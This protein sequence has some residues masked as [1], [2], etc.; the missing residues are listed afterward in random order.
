[1][2]P[3]ERFERWRTIRRTRRIASEYDDA[4]SEGHQEAL[5]ASEPYRRQRQRFADEHREWQRKVDALRAL[6]AMYRSGGTETDDT[7]I[8]NDGERLLGKIDGAA[9]IEPTVGPS[10]TSSN[11]G[12]VSYR[13]TRSTTVR[14]GHGESTHY[15]GD[16]TPREADTGTAYV[17]TD[18]IGFLGQVKSTTWTL[19]RLLSEPRIENGWI[20]L[21]VANRTKTSGLWMRNMPEFLTRIEWARAIAE[22]A[23][24][25]VLHG[26]E[27]QLDVL[28]KSE[29]HDAA[30]WP[31][32]LGVP[33]DG[34]SRPR[35][36]DQRGTTKVEAIT[37][38]AEGAADQ[39]GFSALLQVLSSDSSDDGERLWSAFAI[40]VRPVVAWVLAAEPEALSRIAQALESALGTQLRLE[41]RTEAVH[42]LRL[43]TLADWLGRAS[44]AEYAATAVELS[45]ALAVT[46]VSCIATVSTADM[47][48]LK[49]RASDLVIELGRRLSVHMLDTVSYT[50]L[51]KP[52]L[53]SLTAQ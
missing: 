7:V 18:R 4:L 20:P 50:A 27:E 3:R 14:A 16:Q 42:L 11:W 36:M 19:D 38:A 8:L 46:A 41:P 40:D 1:M 31:A 15:P 25:D 22:G 53:E 51:A 30:S 28:N 37:T 45:A 33:P 34:D 10:H 23:M 47:G 35:P 48:T 49:V 2:G 6:S 12:G 5:D 43:P 32:S 13:L 26:I 29:P 24:E 17:T 9:L 39:A 44:D 52:M 21:H